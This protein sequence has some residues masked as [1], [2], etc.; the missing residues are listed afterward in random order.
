MAEADGQCAAT[1]LKAA[2]LQASEPIEAKQA[3]T[4]K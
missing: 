1:A 4:R 2:G 3:F